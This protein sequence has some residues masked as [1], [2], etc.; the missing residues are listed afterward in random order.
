[1]FRHKT[2][3]RWLSFLL[4]CSLASSL[5]AQ[6]PQE[7]E[8]SLTIRV[9]SR[10]VVV[11]VV[12]TDKH[13]QPVL[14]LQPTDF[15]ITEKG[16]PQRISVFT[17]PGQTVKLAAPTLP[18]GVYSNRPEYRAPGGP[19]TVILLDAANTPLENQAEARTQMMKFAVANFRPGNEVAVLALTNELRLLQDF[20]TDPSVLQQAFQRYGTQKPGHTDDPA[21][22]MRVDVSGLGVGVAAARVTSSLEAFRKEELTNVVDH[23]VEITLAAL[24]ALSRILGGIPGRKNVIWL[25]AGFP[26]SLLPSQQV[27]APVESEFE[28]TQARISKCETY[29]CP[30]PVSGAENSMNPGQQRVYTSQIRNVS[31][32]L[33]SAQIAIYPVDVRGLE[34]ATDSSSYSSQQAMKEIAAET[35]GSAFINRNDIHTGVERAMADHAASYTIGYYPVNKNW[36]GNY[37]TISVKVNHEGVEVRHRSGY[38]AVDPAKENEK[39]FQRDLSDAIG[40][41]ISAT[42]ITFYAKV[43]AI[44]KGKTQVEFMVDGD[45]ISVEDAGKGKHLNLNFEVA[46]FA[47]DGKPISTRMM[48]VDKVLPLETYQQIV[49]QGLSVRL[50]VDTPPGKS[51]AWLAVRDNHDGYVGTLQASVGQ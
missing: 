50:D 21:E 37:R 33:A 5:A 20:T 18:P 25:S 48:K 12:V 36:D 27:Q 43:S 7:P 51:L 31:A 32:Q 3:R 44:E 28:A 8:P 17:A 15:T 2:E 1:M 10:L 47:P 38:F 23:R 39:L 16:K 29:G 34:T 14:G 40:D 26:F 6:S 11:D 22:A 35:G 19:P 49:Q 13:G 4:C 24:R 46:I 9:S 45:S 42:Q 30:D 41:R